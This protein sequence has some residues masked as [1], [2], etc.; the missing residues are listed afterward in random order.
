MPDLTPA[1]HAARDQALAELD[2]PASAFYPWTS[3]GFHYDGRQGRYVATRQ[4]VEVV[5]DFAT[6]DEVRA[7]IEAQP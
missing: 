5:G 6:A 7:F 4:H 1:E 2:D 3:Y